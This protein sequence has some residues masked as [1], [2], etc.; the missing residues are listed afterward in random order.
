MDELKPVFGFPKRYGGLL[1][2]QKPVSRAV[3]DNLSAFDIK[4]GHVLNNNAA[5]KEEEKASKPA[6][7]TVE[8]VPI[9]AEPYRQPSDEMEAEAVQA[10]YNFGNDMIRVEEIAMGTP[11]K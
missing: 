7:K 11:V 10:E 2:D 3:D 8:H 6:E 1:S 9:V 5:A 4:T